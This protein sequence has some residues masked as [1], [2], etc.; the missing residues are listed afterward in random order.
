MRRRRSS[1]EPR[2][3]SARLISG[4]V[5]AGFVAVT[6]ACDSAALVASVVAFADAVALAAVAVAFAF[7]LLAADVATRF[8]FAPP[9]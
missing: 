1:C 2:K 7:V 3:A 6:T 9:S 5:G 4:I 8:R